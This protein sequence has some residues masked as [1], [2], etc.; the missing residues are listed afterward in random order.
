VASVLGGDAVGV[1]DDFFA[2]A[3]H[4]PLLVRLAAELRRSL[5]STLPVAA[6]FSAEGTWGSLARWTLAAPRSRA[7]RY[8]D[9]HGCRE[10]PFE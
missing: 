6:L 10:P 7:H 2:L 1:H 4:S 9:R 8:P 5:I 3:G